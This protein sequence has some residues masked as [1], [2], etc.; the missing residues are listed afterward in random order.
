MIFRGPKVQEG[1]RS[2]AAGEAGPAGT[3]LGQPARSAI[4]VRHISKLFQRVSGSTTVAVDDISLS[5]AP[6]E[7][8]A[9][10]GPSGCGKTTLLR[11]IAGLERP[12]H[13]E[14]R[15]GDQV[16]FDATRRR[17]T[18]PERRGIGMMFQSYALWPHMTVAQNVGYPLRCRGVAGKQ[19]GARVSAILGTVGLA[20]LEDEP[21]SR[22]SGGQQQRVALA[23]SLVAQ[24]GVV[25]FDEPLSNVDAR[26]REELRL[27]LVQIHKSIGFSGLYVTHDQEDAMQVCDRLV[28]LREGAIE[29]VGTPGDVYRK[30]Q[31]TYV[32]EFVGM[33][34]RISADQVAHEG[35]SLLLG[36]SLGQIV[37]AEQA[38]DGTTGEMLALIRPEHLRISVGTAP[39][40]AVNTWSATV[41]F[42]LFR[43][44]WMQ[45]LVKVGEVELSVWSSDH[46][47]APDTQ[48]SITVAPENVMVR[49]AR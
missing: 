28:V 11:C 38:A 13:G 36:T 32:A 23:R 12:T 43:G 24:P 34:N 49:P 15:I 44:S 6:G 27:E 41:A 33:V 40:G 1:R 10:V 37:A 29:Q 8:V 31:T 2:P 3:A 14:I 20:G 48:V 7:L 18:P 9:V 30:P 39:A 25:L 21:P 42:S 35:G 4:E 16:V 46:S 22:L 5:V 47:I 19:I 26:V 45:Y 17:F